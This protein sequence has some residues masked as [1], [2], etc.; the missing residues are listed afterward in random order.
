[1]F[2]LIAYK[3]GQQVYSTQNVTQKSVDVWVGFIGT[4]FDELIIEPTK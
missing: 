2:N 3:N 1:M 4:R